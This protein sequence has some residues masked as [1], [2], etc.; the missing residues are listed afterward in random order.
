MILAGL[1]N[2]GDR[3][4][5]TRHNIGFQV[6][7]L[8]AERWGRP[9]FQDKF[10]SHFATAALAGGGRVYLQKPQTFMNVSG[11]AVQPAAAFYKVSPADI[12]VIHDE[13]DLPFGRVA[14]K[15]G[16]GSGGHNGLKSLTQ[17]LGTPEFLRLRVGIG[18]PPAEFRGQVAD[19][20]LQRF[21]AEEASQLPEILL[22]SAEAVDLLLDKGL[23]EAMNRVNR[24]K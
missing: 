9:L 8:I 1:G 10:R 6:V 24:K 12:L 20:V 2:P 7:A 23:A 3:Y 17:R 15:K 18:R 19:Y 5:E 21:S 13:L 11:D 22:K 4:K 16:G 14:L